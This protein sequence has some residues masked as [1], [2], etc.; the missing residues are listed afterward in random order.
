MHADSRALHNRLRRIEG[1]VRGLQ[2]MVDEDAYCVDILTQ[3]AAVQTALE[4][5]AV[6]VLDGHVRHCVADAV[7]GDGR[8]RGRRQARRA[9]GRRAALREGPLADSANWPNSQWPRRRAGVGSRLTLLDERWEGL[10]DAPRTDGRGHAPGDA[11]LRR[12]RLRGAGSRPGP[13]GLPHRAASRERRRLHRRRPARLHRRPCSTRTFNSV[14]VNN[15]G[16][17]TFAHALAEFTPFDFRETGDP[18]IA[19]FFADVDTS[20]AGSGLVTYGT[21]RRLR[22]PQG[23]LRHLGSRRLLRSHT[24]KLNTFQLIIVDQAAGRGDFDIVANYDSITWETGDASDGA[25][26][27]GGTSAV[28][29]LRGRRRRRGARAD[30]ARLVRQRRP[31]RLQRRHE[32]RWSL[33]GRPAARALRVPA[34]PDRAHGRAAHRHRDQPRRRS[35]AGRAGPGLPRRR[36]LRV[37]DRQQRR[38]LHRGPTC[39]RAP[40]PSPPSRAPARR[41]RRRR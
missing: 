24:D 39:R 21:G 35:G 11:R 36:R 19:P 3:V 30:G 15:N 33:D 6:N 10:A 17:V 14:F 2:R 16:N 23:V 40:T 31:A 7:A 13:P 18:I 22:R 20:G 27:F 34:A 29:G 4:Q 5:V 12:D 37:A 41:T 1:Q 38:P 26:G 8:G 25:N 28:R 32:P 9:D